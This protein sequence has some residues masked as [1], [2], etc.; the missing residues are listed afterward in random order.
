MHLSSFGLISLKGTVIKPEPGLGFAEYQTAMS[1]YSATLA[2]KSSLRRPTDPRLT[3]PG[4]SKTAPKNKP[5]ATQL[6]NRQPAS[7]AAALVRK[8]R[9]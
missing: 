3:S 5:E 9:S 8:F 7:A 2:L 1:N 6:L 4:A